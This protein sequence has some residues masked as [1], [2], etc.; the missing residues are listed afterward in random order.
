MR[1]QK[2]TAG[3]CITLIAA[4]MALVSYIIYSV[5]ISGSGYF[6]N[7]A[8][9]HTLPLCIGSCVLLIV[10]ALPGLMPLEG[11]KSKAAQLVSGLLRI[12]APAML[13][14]CFINL[15]AAR[16]EGL[17]Y[18]YFSNEE[19]LKEVQTAANLS[20]ATGTIANMVCLGV[21]MLCGIIAAFC[22]V[23]KD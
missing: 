18:I 21:A 22:R 3:T 13:A 2:I 7:A 15:V 1:K 4:V 16:A 20:S 12:A 23:H 9:S 17:G 10:A 6:Q 5:N 8:V 14:L 19:V 11:G